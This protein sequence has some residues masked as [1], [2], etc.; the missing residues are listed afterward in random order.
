M[1]QPTI[2]RRT[3]DVDVPPEMR[4]L[5][6]D[7]SGAAELACTVT[8]TA[9]F[10]ARA[11]LR[12]APTNGTARAWLLPEQDEERDF[13][14]GEAQPFKVTLRVP[15]SERP[16]AGTYGFR[17]DVANVAN[18]QED[19]TEGPVVAF[20]VAPGEDPRR[21]TGQTG[22]AWLV[23]AAAAVLLL[24]VGGGILAAVLLR[25][26]KVPPLEGKDLLAV[27]KELND[28]G[29]LLGEF[30]EGDKPGAAVGTVIAQ[31]PQKDAKAR[32]GDRVSVTMQMERPEPELGG[33]LLKDVQA[34]VFKAGYQ[35]EVTNVQEHAKP[36]GTV[37]RQPAD[38]RTRFTLDAFPSRPSFAVGPIVVEVEA[39]AQGATMPVV[40]KQP[41]ADAATKLA[42]ANI[43]FKV[44]VV[45]APVAEIGEVYHQ[46]K[47]ANE[48][49]PPTE[50]VELVVR[51]VLVPD[52]NG[53]PL[54]KAAGALG[55]AKLTVGQII[56]PEDGKV[57]L[58][59]PGP[60]EA[61]LPGTRVHI[62]LRGSGP[63]TYPFNRV[64]YYEAKAA[65]MQ[66]AR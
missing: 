26:P 25:S 30:S 33:K 27:E 48:T 58:T 8:N 28:R 18:P 60:G 16:A 57:F 66:A 61:A 11:K 43:A 50:Q 13:R 10:P 59:E 35:L 49:V 14:A 45:L 3:F 22:K 9:A 52:L 7:G 51:G 19:Y 63:G 5:Y 2:T 41:L 62:W 38:R 15:M 20:A 36:S 21:K 39:T 64:K 12:I 54:L 29:L 34:D 32:K 23:V 46:S 24:L 6:P 37:L 42:A 53:M 40:T 65:A 4:T 44:T 47:R 56:G 55:S 1:A 17:V 31:K